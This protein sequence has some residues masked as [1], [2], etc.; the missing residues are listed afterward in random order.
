MLYHGTI[1]GSIV[2]SMVP[3]CRL[4]ESACSTAESMSIPIAHNSDGPE[5]EISCAAIYN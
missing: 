4:R 1:H 3:V 2:E 5:R